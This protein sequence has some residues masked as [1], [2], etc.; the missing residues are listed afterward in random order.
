MIITMHQSS[1]GIL[2]DID[3]GKLDKTRG[4]GIRAAKFIVMREHILV[5]TSRIHR[6][7]TCYSFLQRLKSISDIGDRRGGS[8][9]CGCAWLWP[10]A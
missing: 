1:T 9:K 6:A 8:I 2:L 10:V 4:P 3:P 7:A 5:P